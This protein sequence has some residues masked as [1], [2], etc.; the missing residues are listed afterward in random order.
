LCEH[1]DDYAYT[2]DEFD[3]AFYCSDC[4]VAHMGDCKWDDDEGEYCSDCGEPLDDT[5][6][7]VCVVTT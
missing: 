2:A 4:G 5:D 7:H 6:D 3:E 1:A